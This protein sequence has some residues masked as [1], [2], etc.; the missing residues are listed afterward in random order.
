MAQ[1]TLLKMTQNILSEM[2]EDEVNSINDSVIALQVAGTIE[3]T[4]FNII[5]SKDSWPWLKELFALTSVADVNKPT[6]MQIPS[7][8]VDVE[9]VK[10]N[11]RT[12]T[13][14]KDKFT[15]IQYKDP[16][17]FLKI[18]EVRDSSA[19]TVQVVTEFGGTKL[20]IRN[21]K[22]P[23]Y[24]TSFDDNYIV[25]DSFDSDV[26]SVLQTSKTQCRGTRYPTFTLSD[27]FV[28]RKSVV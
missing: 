1:M 14:T 17:A 22:A 4:Y 12:T 16:Q 8:I 2:E 28:D 26:D 23:Q 27:S 6:H 21:D 15:N 13:D 20:N 5:D 7:N 10:Y 18:L 25:F 19:A 11:V 3:S 24:W 9:F